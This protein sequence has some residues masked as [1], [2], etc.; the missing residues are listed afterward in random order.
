V[1]ANRL[2]VEP[3]ARFALVLVAAIAAVL[4]GLPES[5]FVWA[6]WFKNSESELRWIGR[7]HSRLLISEAPAPL[8]FG[9]A[10][11]LLSALVT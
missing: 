4:G 8:T 11:G 6:G 3:S 7:S 10:L 5:K 9:L 2:T 1:L